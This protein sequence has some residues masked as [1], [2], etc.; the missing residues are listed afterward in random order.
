[1]EAIQILSFWLTSPFGPLHVVLI[2]ID[3]PSSDI[4]M[5]PCAVCFP[6]LSVLVG[7]GA[8]RVPSIG[9]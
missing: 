2:V 3:L 9:D 5:V 6:L 4:V 8:V 1:M 7:G